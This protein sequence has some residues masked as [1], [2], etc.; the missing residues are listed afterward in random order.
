MC[1]TQDMNQAIR[2]KRAVRQDSGETL[3]RLRKEIGVSP[4]TRSARER[5]EPCFS[6][7]DFPKEQRPLRIED[8][9]EPKSKV[10]D[11]NAKMAGR[12]QAR[13]LFHYVQ[14]PDR[15]ARRQNPN[16]G[17][18]RTNKRRGE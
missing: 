5:L 4:V 13:W 17:P 18:K 11:P 16:G 3:D 9:S 10:I 2:S 8:E 15:P 12:R 1:K 7:P 6:D 14:E